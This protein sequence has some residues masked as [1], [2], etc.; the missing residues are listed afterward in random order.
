MSYALT[1]WWQRQTNL[2]LWVL[3]LSMLAWQPAFCCT[4]CCS[5][6]RWHELRVRATCLMEEHGEQL[7]LCGFMLVGTME[8]SLKARLADSGCKICHVALLLGGN[9]C[10]CT[11]GYMIADDVYTVQHVVVAT[12]SAPRPLQI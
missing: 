1:L 3:S 2:L 10:T 6:Q 12:N 8:R 7:P 4:S 9:R 11:N 5:P